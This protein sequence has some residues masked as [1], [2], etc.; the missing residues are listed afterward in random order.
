[1]TVVIFGI[2]TLIKNSNGGK[3]I[4]AH[5]QTRIFKELNDPFRTDVVEPTDIDVGSVIH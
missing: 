5:L 2:R 3:H 1:M 4:G